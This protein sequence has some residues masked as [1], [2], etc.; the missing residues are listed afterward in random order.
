MLACVPPDRSIGY[1]AVQIGK[2]NLLTMQQVCSDIFFFQL[3]FLLTKIQIDFCHSFYH[4]KIVLFHYRLVFID[5]TQ[6]VVYE[7]Y[8]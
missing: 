8:H 7:N 2:S 4:S 5:E 3:F 1:V 6:I